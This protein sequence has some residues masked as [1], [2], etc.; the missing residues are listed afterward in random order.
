MTRAIPRVAAWALLCA[1]VPITAAFAKTAVHDSTRVVRR[2]SVSQNGI[3]IERAGDD[4]AATSAAIRQT[5]R[6]S[7]HRRIQIS[8]R[9]GFVTVDGDEQGLVRVFADAE[10]PAG[11]RIEGDVV[12]VC[13]SV[14]VRGQVSGN[15]VAVAGSVKLEPGSSVDGDAV[16]VGGVLDQ[17]EGAR[18]GG[19]SVSLGF[20]P[21]RFGVPTVP[22]LLLFVFGGWLLTLFIGMILTLVAPDRMVR[23]AATSSRRTGLSLLLGLVSFPASIVAGLLLLI[24]VVGI[25]VAI[26]LPIVYTVM[27][28]AGQIAAS[29]VVGCKL[30][31][32][33]LGEGS[34]MGPIAAGSLFVAL[35]FVAGAVLASPPGIV[36][37]VALFFTA[38]GG[39]MVFGLSAIGTGAVLVSRF[40]TQPADVGAERGSHAAPVMPAGAVPPPSTA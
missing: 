11:E 38:L 14:V 27:V 4:D 5:I 28:W 2:V 32:R 9:D 1:L 21:L 16:A 25:P 39:L 26:L 6:D 40:G 15:V 22:I 30:L 31:R 20:L 24:T 18:V 29:Y 35:F 33:R 8:S 17:A 19:E 13:G 7:I 10:V 36:R 12:A 34:A 23:I 37:T 3:E